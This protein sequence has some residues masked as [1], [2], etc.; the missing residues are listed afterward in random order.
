MQTIDIGINLIN[1]RFQYD[2]NEVI[3]RAKDAGVS[4]MI[5]TGVSLFVSQKSAQ[6]A[7]KHPKNLFSTAGLHPHNAKDW[8]NN[9]ADGIKKLL[10]LPEVVAVGECGLDFDR[11]FS[12]RP[13]QESCFRAQLQLAIDVNKPLFLHEREA[14]QRF[15]AIMNEYVGKLP[16]SVVHCFTGTFNEAEKY[17]DMGF[18]IG[19]TGAI[20][21]ERRFGH[22]KEVVKYIP[23]DRLM[24]ETDAPFMLPKNMR[25]QPAER[26]NEPAYL[27]FVT[28]YIAKNTGKT[29]AEVALA[30]T[31]TAKLFFGL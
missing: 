18:Y 11:D 17:L 31:N 2:A 6:L 23:S 21:D 22:L 24:I 29:E 14:H 9:V 13:V 30:T 7:K 4:P 8:D 1:K 10:L 5:L 26:R 16:K 12:P 25:E 19:I 27:P 20:T 15:V 3:Q 28:Q